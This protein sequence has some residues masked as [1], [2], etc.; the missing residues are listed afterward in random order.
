VA[1]G[2]GGRTVS[3]TITQKQ[4]RLK[5]EPGVIGFDQTTGSSLGRGGTKSAC[6]VVEGGLRRVENIKPYASS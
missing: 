3:D 6:G 5:D 4:K 1:T 2:G